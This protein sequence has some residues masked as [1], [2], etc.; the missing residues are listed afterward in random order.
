MKS[1]SIQNPAFTSILNQSADT[2]SDD[3]TTNSGWTQVGTL[4]DVDNI[5]ADKVGATA[6]PANA[7]HR[8][9]K[10]LGVTLS[11]TLWYAE[12]DFKLNSRSGA[13]DYEILPFLLTAGTGD[14]GTA[15]QDY[16][17]FDTYQA[18]GPVQKVRVHVRD[19]ATNTYG[20]LID[21]TLTTQYYFRLE[22]TTAINL[23]ISIFT[24]SG[25]TTHTTGSPVNVTIPST[26]IGLTH[27][28]HSSWSNSGTSGTSNFELDN[29]RIYNNASP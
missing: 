12:F 6:V 24:D 14:P 19:G 26:V 25:R 3:Y 13:V 2:F 1:L 21:I 5:V 4:I 18:A 8:V 11:D 20:T 9:Y 22:R 17:G 7:E 10:T 29:T 16:C 23:R 15:T 28:Q 27:I